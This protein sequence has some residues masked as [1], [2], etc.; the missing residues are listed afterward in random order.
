[1]NR[2]EFLARVREAAHAGRQY[3]VTIAEHVPRECCSMIEEDLLVRLAAEIEAVGGHAHR[4]SDD[5]AARGALVGLLDQYA[6]RAALVWQHPLLDELGLASVLAEKGIARHD[7]DN[8]APLGR[9]ECRRRM[10]AADVG[11]SSADFAIAESGTLAVCSQAGQ[12]RAVSLLPLVH[13]AIVRREQVLAD[14]FDLF[15]RLG[16][17]ELQSSVVLITGPSKTGD[18]ELT[19]TTG[20]HGPRQW[21]VILI[22]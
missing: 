21:H 8:L 6:P 17:G 18:I 13:V 4:V 14:L 22:G 20:V 15:E 19:L 2:D 7:Y 10:L 16:A 9:D 11:I 1:M 3:R 12:E 5:N